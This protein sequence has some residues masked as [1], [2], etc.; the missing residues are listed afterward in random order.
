MP[1]CV[2][3]TKLPA[4]SLVFE[5]EMSSAVPVVL[6][7]VE[8]ARAVAVVR[9]LVTISTTFVVVLLESTSISSNLARPANV[10]RR[11]DAETWRRADEA[12]AATRSHPLVRAA[13]DA[14][15]EA[16]LIDDGG[17][18]PQRREIPWSRN[19]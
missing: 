18:A 3:L 17:A 9:E 8:M 1:V 10:E 16:E 19:A 7:S 13:F 2:I 5:S 15:P 12:A 11:I 14:F 4:L 6:A